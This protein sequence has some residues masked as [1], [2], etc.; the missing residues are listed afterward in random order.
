MQGCKEEIKPGG[1]RETMKSVCMTCVEAVTLDEAR[2]ACKSLR[3]SMVE[4]IYGEIQL[5]R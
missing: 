4:Q 1:I 2:V 5:Y 3:Y